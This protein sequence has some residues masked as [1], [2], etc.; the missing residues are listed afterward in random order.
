MLT[1]SQGSAVVATVPR[2]IAAM[3]GLL[4]PPRKGTVEPEVVSALTLPR[5]A[6]DLI[7]SKSGRIFTINVDAPAL[8]GRVNGELRAYPDA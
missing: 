1:L 3:S 8:V 6:H 7:V 5:P 2:G 4:P